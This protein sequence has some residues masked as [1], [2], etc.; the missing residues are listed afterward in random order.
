M[1]ANYDSADS[2]FSC[3]V[4]FVTTQPTQALSML[5][6]D[7]SLQ[8]AEKLASLVREAHPGELSAQVAM[9]LGRVTQRS[10]RA[11]EVARGVGLIER[12][13]KEEQLEPQMAL[14][15]FCL[16]ALNLNEFVYLD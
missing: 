4:R 9:A 7:F 3:P 6:S 13:T 8:Q 1:L 16:L 10:P 15:N 11:E 2:D 12:W 5:N 14:R